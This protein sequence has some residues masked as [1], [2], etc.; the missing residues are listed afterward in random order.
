[1]SS[2]PISKATR[3]I[4]TQTEPIALPAP[5]EP[6]CPLCSAV[7]PTEVRKDSWEQRLIE[8]ERLGFLAAAFSRG[9]RTSLPVAQRWPGYKNQVWAIA[10]PK[11][12]CGTYSSWASAKDL[13]LDHT[14]GAWLDNTVCYGFASE[15]ECTM[16]LDTFSA[17]TEP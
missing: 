14:T 5:A 4:G 3:S 9:I 16:F 1:M 2:D 7:N 12:A 10:A 15:K 8:A 17:A 11:E 13:L 6:D